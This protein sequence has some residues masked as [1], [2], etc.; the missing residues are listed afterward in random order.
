MTGKIMKV[1]TDK[2]FGYFLSEHGAYEYRNGWHRLPVCPFCG[3]EEKFGIHLGKNRA[4]CFR[5]DYDERLL[6]CVVDAENLKTTAQAIELLNGF[7]D[8]QYVEPKYDKVEER[9]VILPG[10]FRTLRRGDS[11][12]AEMARK[13]VKSRGFDYKELS[14]RGVGYTDD[15]ESKYWGYLIV[16]FHKDKK[17][18]YF[19]TRK[20]FGTGP[21]FNNPLYEDFGIG[22]NQVIYN[23]DALNR[24]DEVNVLESFTNAWTL[25]QNSVGLNGK[26]LSMKQKALI[27]QSKCTKVNILLDHDAWEY[28]LELALE[29]LDY[30]EI[31]VIWFKDDRDVND[32]GRKTVLEMIDNTPIIDNFRELMKLKHGNYKI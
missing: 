29:L 4:H 28:A 13:Y 21:K 9:Q 32:L 1:L 24:Y 23:S 10:G 3:R 6:Q 22:K 5:C 11:R 17:V 27:L 14:R 26:T 25:G 31:R 30:K 7:K 19:Q 16:P 2:L 18:I 15:S 20:F 12:M 8:A